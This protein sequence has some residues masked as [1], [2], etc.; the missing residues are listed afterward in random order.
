[1]SNFV[2][3][4]VFF[5]FRLT[6]WLL[7]GKLI[8]TNRSATTGDQ[9]HHCPSKTQDGAEV[10]ALL[11]E[12]QHCGVW[13]D[14]AWMSAD[15]WRHGGWSCCLCLQ[16]HGLLFN[17]HRGWIW[18]TLGQASPVVVMWSYSSVQFYSLML[19]DTHTSWYKYYLYSAW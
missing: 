13:L 14:H 17:K 5:F 15:K 2:V 16:L 10:S 19:K 12:I 3:I 6:D 18:K 11:W 7:W 4:A 9:E 1:M 8:H